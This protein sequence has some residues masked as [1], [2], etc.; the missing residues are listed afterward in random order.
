MSTYVPF[1]GIPSFE[2][3]AVDLS[4]AKLTVPR[5]DL[6]ER[7]LAIDQVVNLNATGHV[8]R[9]EYVVNRRT[10]K[11]ERHHVVTVEDVHVV[12]GARPS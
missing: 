2:G 3:E 9:I 10:G 6:E 4:Y 11:L 7:T 8:T 1:S 5:L 12:P